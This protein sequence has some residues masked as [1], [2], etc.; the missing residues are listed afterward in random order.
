ML[1]RGALEPIFRV[2][3]GTAKKFSRAGTDLLSHI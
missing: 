3:A 2:P 1:N